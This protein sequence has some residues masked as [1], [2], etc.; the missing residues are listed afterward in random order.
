MIRTREKITLFLLVILFSLFHLDNFFFWDNIVQLSVPANWY[1]ENGFSSFFLPDEIAT[2]HPTFTGM[3]LTV[4]WKIFGKSLPVSHLAMLPLVFGLIYQI[5]RFVKTLV[6]ENIKYQWLIIIA[7]LADTSL[8]A[9]F[10]ILTFEVAHLFF[11]FLAINEFL[12]NRTFFFVIAFSGLCLISL[13]SILSAGG[14]VVF[15]FLLHFLRIKKV[16]KRQ[17]CSLIPG[18]LLFSA[19]MVAFYLQKGWIVHNVVSE[20][21]SNASEF[22]GF[23]NILK[24][25]AGFFWFILDFGRIGFFTIAFV[26]LLKWLTTFIPP[27]GKNKIKAFSV[28]L[29]KILRKRKEISIPVLAA[30][31]QFMIFFPVIV[32]HKNTFGP[33]YLIPIF[34]PILTAIIIWILEYSSHKRILYI[35]GLICL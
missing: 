10:S 7:L 20:K 34:I 12:R 5:V 31:A 19:F 17:F 13:R 1:Y 14:I 29:M 15:L 35:T 21:W 28:E 27:H 4:F 22:S 24:N 2:G 18:I 16:T 30:I 11:F 6:P 23:Y 9:Q 3:Y 8:M 32:I 26:V 33:R 25:S